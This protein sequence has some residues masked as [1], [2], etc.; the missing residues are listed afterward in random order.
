MRRARSHRISS[1]RLD[2]VARAFARP[3]KLVRDWFAAIII[4]SCT[5]LCLRLMLHLRYDIIIFL[6]SRTI[7][8]A[9]TR[10]DYIACPLF[11]RLRN[12]SDGS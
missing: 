2:A 1:H 10:R 3:T 6:S 5:P 12:P 11:R 7:N 4:V 9:N 8:Y